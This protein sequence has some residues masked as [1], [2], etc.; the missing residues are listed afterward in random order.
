MGLEENKSV[1]GRRK[2]TCLVGG[3]GDVQGLAEELCLGLQ[4]ISFRHKLSVLSL[5]KK[6]KENKKEK[7]ELQKTLISLIVHFSSSPTARHFFP[8]P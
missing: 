8:V 1:L 7:G 6:K 3:G 5:L 2:H 4:T